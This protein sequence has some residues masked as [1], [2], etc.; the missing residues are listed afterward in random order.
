MTR[1]QAF[2]LWMVLVNLAAYLHPKPVGPISDN[3]LTA[4]GVSLG[5]Y[6]MMRR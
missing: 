3:L 6:F 2:G 1:W 5:L 4:V